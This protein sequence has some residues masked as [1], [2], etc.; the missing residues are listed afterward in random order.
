MSVSL[1]KP[2]G[3]ELVLKIE[4]S[5]ENDAKGWVRNRQM[6]P[7][8]STVRDYK[9]AGAAPRKTEA[10]QPAFCGNDDVDC[11]HR[12]SLAG[13]AGGIPD[14]AQRLSALAATGAV[15]V[16]VQD[17][18]VTEGRAR[19]REF[20]GGNPNFFG[21][22]RDQVGLWPTHSDASKRPNQ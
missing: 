15:N 21:G 14:L 20:R 19:S 10:S 22:N 11:A 12:Q 9:A 3:L 13:P 7:K 6:I 1:L 2:G 8:K 18:R 4:E 17:T 5:G 16:L